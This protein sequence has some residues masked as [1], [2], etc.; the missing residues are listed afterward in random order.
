MTVKSFWG[1]FDAEAMMVGEETFATMFDAI[2]YVKST[3]SYTEW[4]ECEF[5]LNRFDADIDDNMSIVEF[6]D[7]INPFE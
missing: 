4:N 3:W 7:Q 2:D 1:I 5:T 6:T